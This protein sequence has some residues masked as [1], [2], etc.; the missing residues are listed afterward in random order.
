MEFD[1]VRVHK[2]IEYIKSS[3]FDADYIDLVYSDLDMILEKL[4]ISV[5][6]TNQEK[7]EILKSILNLVEENEFKEI[8]RIFSGENNPFQSEINFGVKIK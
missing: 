6:L 3:N 1:K 4:E 7:S 2:I 8:E 5:C